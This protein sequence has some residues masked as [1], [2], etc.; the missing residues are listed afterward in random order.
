MAE[1]AKDIVKK[2]KNDVEK[3]KR[4]SGGTAEHHSPSTSKP[5]ACLAIAEFRRFPK[6]FAAPKKPAIST[7]TSSKINSVPPS[8]SSPIIPKV[9]TRTAK[10]DGVNA[11]WTGDKTRDRCIELLYDALALESG[12]R[13]FLVY[14]LLPLSNPRYPIANDLIAQ[15]AVAIEKAVAD[16]LG[17]ITGAYKAKIRSLFVNLKDK[18]NPSLRESVVSGDI[19]PVKF[20]NMTSEVRA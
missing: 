14:P 20:A 9:E 11:N 13:T 10:G 15:R 8:A 12:A 3:A 4:T 5:G 2:W 16:E 18:N 17:S 7:A 6:A 1:A 19:S